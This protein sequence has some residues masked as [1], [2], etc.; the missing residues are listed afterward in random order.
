MKLKLIFSFC[1]DKKIILYPY[2]F[3]QKNDF[4]YILFKMKALNG[5]IYLKHH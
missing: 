4:L 2:V 1:V 5:I 3:N